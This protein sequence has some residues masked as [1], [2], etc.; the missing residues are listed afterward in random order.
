MLLDVDSIQDYRSRSLED[1]KKIFSSNI[2]AC[3]LSLS[4]N[5]VF[6]FLYQK[7]SDWVSVLAYFAL[8]DRGFARLFKMTA[9]DPPM[10]LCPHPCRAVPGSRVSERSH[11]DFPCLLWK[12]AVGHS[13]DN[14]AWLMH[15]LSPLVSPGKV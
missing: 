4:L 11:S 13:I 3:H 7:K 15:K 6:R 9:A 1:L 5:I 10:Q 12:G 14:T 2:F 8:D